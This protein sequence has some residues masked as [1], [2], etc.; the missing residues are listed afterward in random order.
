MVVFS[1]EGTAVRGCPESAYVES[2]LRLTYC[3]SVSVPRWVPTLVLAR[4]WDLSDSQ[5]WGDG[6]MGQVLGGI[7]ALHTHTGLILT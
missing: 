6:E 7:S 3:S 4:V 1:H 2:F 5:G